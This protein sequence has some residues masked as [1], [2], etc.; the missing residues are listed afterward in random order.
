MNP[1]RWKL[2][3]FT[4]WTGQA[5]SLVGSALVRF[6]LIWWLTERTGSATVLATASLVS[7]LPVIVLG[8]FAGALVDRWDRRWVMIISDAL[9]ALFTAF[10]AYLY[11]LEIARVWHVYAILFLRSLGNGF[12]GPAMRASTSLMA[13]KDQLARVGGMNETVQGV[14]NVVS[15]PLGALLLEI[16]S[17]QGTLSIDIVTAVIAIVPLF[18]VHVPQPEVQDDV[19]ERSSVVRDVVEGF[20]YVWEWR[21][22]FFLLLV[23][24]LMRFFLAPSMTL[25]PLLVTQHFGGKALELGWINSAHG[26]GFV[27]GGI[28]LSLWGG[29]KRRTVTA[30]L[31]LIGVGLGLLGLSLVPATAF[32]LAVVVMFFRT[33]MIPFIR[34]SVLAIFQSYVPPEIQ[35]RVFTLIV[36][37][38]SIMAPLGLAIGG[39]LA[40]AFS[41]RLLFALGGFGCLL[42][43][44]AWAFNPTI[45]HLEDRPRRRASEGRQPAAGN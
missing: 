14:V 3:F 7:T 17:M 33:M 45:M 10:L 22:L 44:L 5:F 31:G 32:G 19:E 41:V 18:I 35:G 6:A 26:F 16:L 9:I 11:W 25:L 27:A 20:H 36:S 43:A 38:V 23:L 4:V 34:G 28:I 30:L 15:P 13:P 29:S 24:A 21:G 40:D 12:Q 8:P 2:P 1:S 37:A 39:P 42:I